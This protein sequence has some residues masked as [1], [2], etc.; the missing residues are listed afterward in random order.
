MSV[1]WQLSVIRIIHST[2]N[3][4]KT[5]SA[6][7]F[8]IAWRSA[9]QQSKFTYLM[10]VVM[11]A[12]MREFRHCTCFKYLGTQT[13]AMYKATLVIKVFKMYSKMTLVFC[14]S[15]FSYIGEFLHSKF[16]FFFYW[17]KQNKS[18]VG[19]RRRHF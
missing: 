18:E 2:S 11:A 15:V 17:L 7:N 19:N 6:D 12:F 14:D 5:Q 9:N 16:F 8:W 3:L 10:A 4:S 1:P 13:Q